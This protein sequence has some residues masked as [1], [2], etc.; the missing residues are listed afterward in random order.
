MVEHMET[1]SPDRESAARLLELADDARAATVRAAAAPWWSFAVLGGALGVCW[2]LLLARAWVLIGIGLVVVVP[3]SMWLNRQVRSRGH[4][5]LSPWFHLQFLAPSSLLYL[6]SGVAIGRLWVSIAYGAAMSVVCL[7]T[8][9][10]DERWRNRR[11]AEGRF[12]EHDIW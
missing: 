2:G 1:N 9:L 4:Y 8:F 5:L 6:L 11:F 3:V 10:L 12:E 7:V